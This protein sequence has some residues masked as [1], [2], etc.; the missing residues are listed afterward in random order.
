MPPLL[1]LQDAG[2]RIL[3]LTYLQ[4]Y[5]DSQQAIRLPYGDASVWMCSNQ[6]DLLRTMLANVDFVIDDGRFLDMAN[7]GEGNLGGRRSSQRSV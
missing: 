7:Q 1:R 3:D 4:Q 5:L 6:T 2:A